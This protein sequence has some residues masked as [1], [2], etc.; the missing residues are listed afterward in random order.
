[1]VGSCS[2]LQILHSTFILKS[3][4]ADIMVMLSKRNIL[5][6][7]FFMKKSEYSAPSFEIIILRSEEGILDNL[8]NSDVDISVEELFK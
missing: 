1:M 5:R 3:Q 8:I 7:R 2:Y 4:I 6:G